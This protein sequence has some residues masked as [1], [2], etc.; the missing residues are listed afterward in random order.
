MHKSRSAITL[1]MNIEKKDFIK[2]SIK[3]K[4][5]MSKLNGLE[6]VDGSNSNKQLDENITDNTD[7]VQSKKINLFS[8]SNNQINQQI[9]LKNKEDDLEEEDLTDD[10]N[11]ENN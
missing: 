2:D 6:D 3:G 4:L 8:K 10:N 11:K 5:M 7:Q 9:I 1:D